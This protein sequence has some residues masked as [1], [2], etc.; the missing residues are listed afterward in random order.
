MSMYQ[1]KR[2]GQGVWSTLAMLNVLGLGLSSIVGFSYL[3]LPQLTTLT[4]DQDHETAL[5]WITAEKDC[6]GDFRLWVDGACW[7]V[8]HDAS[9]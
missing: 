9:F 5:P 1:K 6:E 3:A 2:E 8:E 4:P 7:D